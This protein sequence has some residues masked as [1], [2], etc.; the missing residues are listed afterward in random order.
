[1]CVW[2]PCGFHWS[3]DEDGRVGADGY[4]IVSPYGNEEGI[5]YGEGRGTATGRIEGTVVWSNHPLTIDP[6]L[7]LTRTKLQN[8]PKG[9]GDGLARPETDPKR[10]IAPKSR[11]PELTEDPA[12]RIKRAA[13]PAFSRN[14]SAATVSIFKETVGG[15]AQTPFALGAM[16]W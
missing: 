7:G 10:R 11:I 15:T 2:N 14:K 4:T 13:S 1:M 6:I 12:Q 9:V 5:A 3:Y 16:C 8:T